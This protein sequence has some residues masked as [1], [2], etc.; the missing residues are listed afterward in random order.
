MALVAVGADSSWIDRRYDPTRFALLQS[1]DAGWSSRI[2]PTGDTLLDFDGPRA[3]LVEMKPG[4]ST[5]LL[6]AQAGDMHDSGWNLDGT[7]LAT[8]D[9][10]GGVQVWDVRSGK[11][12]AKIADP[13]PGFS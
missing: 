3:S 11:A 12:L 8:T 1:W 5:R 6:G 7:V 10:G 9:E 2:S 4:G 13:H